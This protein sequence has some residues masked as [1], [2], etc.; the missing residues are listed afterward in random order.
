MV[1]SACGTQPAT[2]T[3][4]FRFT[5]SSTMFRNDAW[6]GSLTVHE[7]SSHAS[8]PSRAARPSASVT[9]LYPYSARRPVMASPS[10]TECEH[11][12]V[13]TYTT[14]RPGT[15]ARSADVAGRAGAAAARAPTYGT[16]VRT[17]AVRAC[18]SATSPSRPAPTSS[19]SMAGG[20]RLEEAGGG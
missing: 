3:G 13:F 17:R 4:L 9:M 15:R 16:R 2:M 18:R 14:D 12:H 1:C 7:L 20:G 11:P 5:P 8:A 19:M 6:L 10:L